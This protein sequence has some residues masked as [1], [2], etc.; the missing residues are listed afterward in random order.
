MDICK[1]CKAKNMTKEEYINFKNNIQ[2]T[3]KAI[4]ST[5]TY[6]GGMYYNT[7]NLFKNA[8]NDDIKAFIIQELKN[9]NMEFIKDNTYYRIVD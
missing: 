1:Y 7:S 9:L 3:A 8:S 2:V 6:K 5:L 4:R